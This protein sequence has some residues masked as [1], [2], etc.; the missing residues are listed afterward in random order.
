MKSFLTSVTYL[1]SNHV[2]SAEK[3]KTLEHAPVRATAWL[4]N[5]KG[6]YW[7]YMTKINIWSHDLGAL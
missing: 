1:C 5:A 2:H 6:M 7:N 4:T 3:I